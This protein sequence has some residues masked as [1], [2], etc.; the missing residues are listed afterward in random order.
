MRRIISVQRVEK[1]TDP[2]GRPYYKTYVMLDDGAE[3]YGFGNDFKLGDLCES[4]YD[5]RWGVH[6][7]RHPKPTQAD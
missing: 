4:F 5:H 1:H 6:K 2:K 3:A 7:I